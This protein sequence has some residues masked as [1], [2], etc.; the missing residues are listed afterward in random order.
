MIRRPPRSTRTDTLFPYTTLFRSTL[1]R[2]AGRR[3][4]HDRGAVPQPPDPRHLRE[5]FSGVAPERPA[6]EPVPVVRLAEVTA[7]AAQRL[8]WSARMPR[9]MHQPCPP[10]TQ[11]TSS[12][13]RP[14][15][16]P[17]SEHT[18]T[19]SNAPRRTKQL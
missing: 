18:H 15:P 10:S 12:M 19:P 14:D 2:A 1:A 9:G 4:R 5:P 7:A 11:G 6:A 13:S 16:H 8:V 3:Q 17:H